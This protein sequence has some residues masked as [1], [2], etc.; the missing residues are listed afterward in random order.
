MS[1]GGFGADRRGD[2]STIGVVLMIGIAVILAAVAFGSFAGLGD[3][4]LS[5]PP[6]AAFEVTFDQGDVGGFDATTDDDGSN[7]SVVVTHESGDSVDWLYFHVYVDGTRVS[8]PSSTLEF[9]A[10][11]TELNAGDQVRITNSAPSSAVLVPGTEIR[12]TYENPNTEDTLV[13]VE[14][15]IP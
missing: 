12:V 3:E 9:D 1:A 2:S 13:L 15:T 5:D 14:A 10:K 7:E 6:N 8:A 4:H 11:P